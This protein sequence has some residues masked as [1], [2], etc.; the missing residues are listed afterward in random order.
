MN[1][2]EEG[3]VLSTYLGSQNSVKW[4]DGKTILNYSVTKYVNPE[5]SVE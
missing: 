3:W 1:A 4:V 5:G 2:R